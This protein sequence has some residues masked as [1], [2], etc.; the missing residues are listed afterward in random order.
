MAKRTQEEWNTIINNQKISGLSIEKYCKQNHIST[1]SFYRYKKV[2][3]TGNGN[4]NTN[5]NQFLPVQVCDYDDKITF[6]LDN[7]IIECNRDDIK[8]ILGGLI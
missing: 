6:K 1:G 7:H 5:D 8:L 3:I 2:L 4:I